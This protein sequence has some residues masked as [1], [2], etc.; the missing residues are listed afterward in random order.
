[1]IRFF[2]PAQIVA[3]LLAA[4]GLIFREPPLVII[5]AAVWVGM[6][7][8]E[9]AKNKPK[10]R[11]STEL[12]AE[13]RALLRPLQ[14]QRREI[15]SLVD[16]NLQNPTVK[17]IGTEALQEADSLISR[18]ESIVVSLDDLTKATKGLRESDYELKRLEEKVAKSS[19]EEEKAA[20][21]DVIE[22]R[23]SE[24]EHFGKVQRA[25]ESGKAKIMEA[26]TALL[27]I[28]AQLTSAALGSESDALDTEGLAGMV[29]RLKSLSN[30]LEEVEQMRDRV[31]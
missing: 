22:V 4:A 1:M 29:G 15:A 6:T 17:V 3:L 14:Q 2:G 11:H 19:S 25:L 24:V 5:G 10:G 21:A 9:T 7:V 26:E 18:A 20:L 8:I 27:A 23:K 16:K 30:S 28:K 31:R 12:S 13:A